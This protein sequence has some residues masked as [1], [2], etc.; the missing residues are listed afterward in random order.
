M[1]MAETD[2]EVEPM[3]KIFARVMELTTIV[4]LVV[5]IVPGLISLSGENVYVD[6]IHTVNNWDK[7]AEEFWH[8]AK[9]ISIHGYDWIFENL[10]R[11][12]CISL[13][14]VVILA[15]APMLSIL[16][17]IPSAPKIYKVIL[18]IVAAELVFA[19]VR[20]LIMAGG[21]H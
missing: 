9:G 18:G 11:F 2:V 7:S 21:G 4:G 5:M 6:P 19:I 15:L 1:K 16:A 13:F 8:D 10:E 20:P 14:G 3:N 17:A 12:D